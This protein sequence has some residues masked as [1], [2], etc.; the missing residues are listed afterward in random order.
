[1]CCHRVCL[2]R[3]T[4]G[5]LSSCA[6]RSGCVQQPCIAERGQTSKRFV[7]NNSCDEFAMSFAFVVV[8]W[9]KWQ[10]FVCFLFTCFVFFILFKLSLNK[11]QAIKRSFFSLREPT[12]TITEVA[13]PTSIIQLRIK[14]LSFIAPQALK[15]KEIIAE[16]KNMH[17]STNARANF[18]SQLITRNINSAVAVF[19]FGILSASLLIHNVT[20]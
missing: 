15:K 14:A 9:F 7:K 6:S 11:P 1:M 17:S 2:H 4:R 19:N 20:L 13:V 8:W 5:T 3:V 16:K 10:R 12:H 18:R